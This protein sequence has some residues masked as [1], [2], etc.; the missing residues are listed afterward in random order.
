[1]YTWDIPQEEDITTA[2]YA[3]DTAILWSWSH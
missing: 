1:L 2:T 3:D